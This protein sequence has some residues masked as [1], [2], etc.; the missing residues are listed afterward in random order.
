MFTDELPV[1]AWP[2]AGKIYTVTLFGSGLFVKGYRAALWVA[3]APRNA[4]GERVW[5]AARFRK[6]TPLTDAEKRAALEE[7]SADQMVPA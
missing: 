4:G 2:E 5:D 6:I 1:H 7:Y 3:D